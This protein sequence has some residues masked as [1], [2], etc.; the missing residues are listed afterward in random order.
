MLNDLL[1]KFK[2]KDAAEEKSSSLVEEKT[3]KT[4]LMDDPNARMIVPGLLVLTIM[5]ALGYFLLDPVFNEVTSLEAKL[6]DQNTKLNEIAARTGQVD[7]AKAKL[8][9]L[10]VKSK[11]ALRYFYTTAELDDLFK[12]LSEVAGRNSLK[13]ISFAK[14]MPRPIYP[15]QKKRKKKPEPIY[16]ERKILI[17]LEGDF[18]SFLRFRNAIAKLDQIVDT[19]KEKIRLVELAEKPGSVSIE[20]TLRTYSLEENS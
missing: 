16:Y 1:A 11:Q 14:K 15:E 13:V 3:S 9:Q 12:S 4:N 20:L 10:Q 5:S 19:A 6:R 2:K 7:I 17:S 8:E 18:V